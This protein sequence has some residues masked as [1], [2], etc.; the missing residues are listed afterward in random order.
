M[1]DMPDLIVHHCVVIIAYLKSELIQVQSA[2]C[3]MIGS[4][5]NNI[6]EDMREKLESIKERTSSSLIFLLK[7]SSPEVRVKSAEAISLL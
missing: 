2:A 5:F 3:I 6:P 4:I 1:T 7:A